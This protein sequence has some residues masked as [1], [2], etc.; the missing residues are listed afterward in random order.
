MAGPDR[1]LRRIG[2]RCRC[3]SRLVGEV[4]LLAGELRPPSL[5]DLPILAE[6]NRIGTGNG[7]GLPSIEPLI[8]SLEDRTDDW[9]E[10]AAVPLEIKATLRML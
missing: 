4:R 7:G 8:M 6:L 1:A 2:L 9:A 10:W 3:F 5:R